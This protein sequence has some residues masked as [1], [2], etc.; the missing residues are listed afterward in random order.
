MNRSTPTGPAPSGRC[1]GMRRHLW[2]AFL[3]GVAALGV[4][5]LTQTS[6]NGLTLVW[7]TVAWAAV[8]ATVGGTLWHGPAR[9][10]PWWLTAGGLT[11]AALA[12]MAAPTALELD[13][14]GARATAGNV[15]NV[16]SNLMI[17][18]A[19]L[20]FVK[21]QTRGD[22]E[23]VIDGLIVTTALASVLWTV[24]IDP[25]ALQA[26]ASLTGSVVYLVAPLLPAGMAS[27][28][29]RLL[30][31]SGGRLAS[32][33]LLGAAW[34]LALLGSVGWVVMLQ[35]DTFTPG[36]W[37]D[38]A[39][40]AALGCAGASA[41]HPSMTEM[42]DLVV[43]PRRAASAG[44][45]T[46]LGFALLATPGGLLLGT[47]RAD[48]SVIAPVAAAGL[49]AV[50]ILA[51]FARLVHEREQAQRELELHALRQEVVARLGQAALSQR[52][53]ATLYDEAATSIAGA[54]GDA[55]VTITSG[56]VDGADTP[57]R[58]ADICLPVTSGE[59]TK[60][61]L[62]VRTEPARQLSVEE[63][64]FLSSSATM[65]SAMTLR[66][67][68]EEDLRRRA[69]FDA[70]TGLP[71]RVLLME[72]TRAVLAAPDRAAVGVVFID[73][74]G[75]KMVNDAHGHG[76]GDALLVSLAERMTQAVRS[77]DMVGRL[78]GDEFVV[79]A[80]HG[81]ATALESLAER[82]LEVL[83]EPLDINGARLLVSASIGA[84]IAAP[85]ESGSEVLRRADAAMYEAKK[86]GGRRAILGWDRVSLQRT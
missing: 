50:L 17:A 72:Q 53:L 76:M 13:P 3:A 79:I 16:V 23:G 2:A 69:H 15:L 70:L 19:V 31:A 62:D 10:G 71:N 38:L 42:G 54:I 5:Y 57:G 34:I 14:A 77:G 12:A 43:A 6:P 36:G 29:V 66:H 59:Q 37:I 24:V 47:G 80:P 82:L 32:A 33:R 74:D 4:L 28:C 51:R 52:P 83:A 75:F 8:A 68:A 27:L 25:S 21:L 67:H 39:W 46:V 7:V 73:L 61:M 60:A 56:D 55:C 44:R 9:P 18:G 78:A 26:D 20:W 48:A 58:A 63:H 1:N 86:A 85:D 22:R 49:I 65:L 11:A 45:L 41:L 40:I 81:D 84:V 64:R 30:F 35:A